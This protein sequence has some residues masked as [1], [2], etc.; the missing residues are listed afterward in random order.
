[1]LTIPDTFCEVF[2][3]LGIGATEQNAELRI[4]LTSFCLL[5]G[6]IRKRYG[7]LPHRATP[8]APFAC[9][10]VGWIV[11]ALGSSK[12]MWRKYR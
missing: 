11:L 1:M 12:K 9:I 7:A 4:F 10:R 3:W 6:L 2:Q 8:G 5:A